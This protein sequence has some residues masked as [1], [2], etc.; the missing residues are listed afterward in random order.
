MCM[1]VTYETKKGTLFFK[2]LVILNS[3]LW[4]KN[5]VYDTDSRQYLVVLTSDD[6]I[7]Y[8]ERGLCDLS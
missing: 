7:L 3:R 1:E 2:Y 8:Q 5:A 6:L 4:T